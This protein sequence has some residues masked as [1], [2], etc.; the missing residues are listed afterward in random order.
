MSFIG[1]SLPPAGASSGLG[2]ELAGRPD[3]DL[4]EA[5]GREDGGGV[6]ATI[7]LI[8]DQLGLGRYGAIAN[9]LEFTV[10]CAVAVVVF[11][12]ARRPTVATLPPM[13]VSEV[14]AEAE[15]A[16]SASPHHTSA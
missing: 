13:L 16:V 12:S 5:P 6:T 4:A 7:S 2:T 1:V 8:L 9:A 10:L 14:I 11:R 3:A 15:A